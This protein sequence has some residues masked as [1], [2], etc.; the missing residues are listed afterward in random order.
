M[1]IFISQDKYV[2]DI[3]KKFDFATVKTTSTPMEPNKALIKDEEADSVDVH[4]YSSM[5]GSLMYLTASRPDIMFVVCACAR[6]QVTPKMSHLHAMKRIFRYLKGQPKL[7]LWYPRDSPFDLEAFSD[8]D[9]ARASI[10]S[11]S[12]IG[13][14]LLNLVT[15]ETVYKEWEDRMER[16]VNTASSLDVEHDS[17]AQ[18]R[19]ETT[20]KKSN[21]PPLSRGYTLRSGE[22]SMKQLELMELCTKKRRK[23]KKTTAVPQPSDS[24]ADVPNEEYVPIHSNDPLLSGEDRLKL[25]NLMDM[26]TKLSERVLDLEHKNCTSLEWVPHKKSRI[27][28]M[29]KALVCSVMMHSSGRSIED[30]DKDAEFSLVDET[31]GRSDDAEMF[32]TDALIEVSTAAPSTTAVPPPDIT[33]VKITLAQI[34]A[35]LKSAKSKMLVKALQEHQHQY[36][37]QASRIKGKLRMD[38]PKVPLKK[39]IYCSDM[40]WLEILK[41]KYKLNSLKKKGL[42]GKRKRKP[43]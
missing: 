10:D 42:Q 27:T 39:R 17:D 36:L 11:K 5:I 1:K 16:A 2:A 12:T 38:E 41:L 18:T 35:K 31:Q 40:K 29:M 6:F 37:L 20:F 7:G 22:D 19:F 14:D 3:L 9:Y 43:T 30:I 24:T 25:T 34:L 4:L 26:C 13:V 21:D 15:Y 28:Q 33:E 23:Q 32:D 8:S